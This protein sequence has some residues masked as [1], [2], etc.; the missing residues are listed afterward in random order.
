MKNK[1]VFIIAIML[2]LIMLISILLIVQYNEFHPKAKC[3]IIIDPDTMKAKTIEHRNIREILMN[4]DYD[5]DLV[6]K[7]TCGN[8]I[9]S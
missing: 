7:T 8:I 5:G 9:L 2:S 6:V 4:K 3:R 1:F